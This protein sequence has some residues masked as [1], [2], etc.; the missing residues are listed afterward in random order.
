[1]LRIVT[2]GA[3][4]GIALRLEGDVVGPWVEILRRCADDALT[5]GAALVLDLSRVAFV[6]RDGLDLLRGLA[7]RGVTLVNASRFVSEQ[8]KTDAR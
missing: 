5:A 2:D 1:V 8:L 3:H 4:P 7:D 6:D